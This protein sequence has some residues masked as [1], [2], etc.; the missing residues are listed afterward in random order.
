[1]NPPRKCTSSSPNDMG[2]PHSFLTADGGEL[3]SRSHV[4]YCDSAGTGREYTAPGK[5]Q[6]NTVVDSVL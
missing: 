5:S 4:D 6:Q 2:R 1:M 3:T